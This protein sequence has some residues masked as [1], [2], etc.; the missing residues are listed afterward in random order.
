MKKLVHRV[1]FGSWLYT[2]GFGSFLPIIAAYQGVLL[3]VTVIGIVTIVR[4]LVIELLPLLKKYKY[5]NLYLAEVIYTSGYGAVITML[6]VF[7]CS[8]EMIAAVGCIGFIP[9]GLLK[10]IDNKFNTMV[11]EYYTPKILEAIRFREAIIESRASILSIAVTSG[12][13]YYDPKSI[14]P[15]IASVFILTIANFWSWYI[16]INSIRKLR[17]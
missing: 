9:Y 3:G 1:L 10:A 15:V 4:Q 7:N 5:K 14:I 13:A 2:L 8:L 16:Y 12:I 17:N 11:S 6:V